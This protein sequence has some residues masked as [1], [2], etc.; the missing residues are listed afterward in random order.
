MENQY[1][2]CWDVVDETSVVTPV[3]YHNPNNLYRKTSCRKTNPVRKKQSGRST[4]QH[5]KSISQHRDLQRPHEVLSN[6][7]KLH[8]EIFSSACIY[9]YKRDG[10]TEENKKISEPH[11]SSTNMPTTYN[12]VTCKVV[13]A[14]KMTGSSSDD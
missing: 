13:C 5:S 7:T 1:F 14:T 9:S 8:I 2:L 11:C 6:L 12:I 10:H 3:M 4:P